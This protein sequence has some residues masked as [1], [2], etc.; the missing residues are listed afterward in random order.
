MVKFF[1]YVLGR[2]SSSPVLVVF[3]S[4][5]TFS[6]AYRRDFAMVIV[7]IIVYY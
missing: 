3:P 6:D 5:M 7:G 4:N 2:N 1:E